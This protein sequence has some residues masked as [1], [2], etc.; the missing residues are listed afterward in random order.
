MGPSVFLYIC[1]Y[2]P[3]AWDTALA[4]YPI[5]TPWGELLKGMTI[6]SPIL[7]ERC[8]N[9]FSNCFEEWE[10][11]PQVHIIVSEMQCSERQGGCMGDS[12]QPQSHDSYYLRCITTAY[13]LY[14]SHITQ[15][16][17]MHRGG[18]KIG[19]SER[20]KR[21]EEKRRR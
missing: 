7:A 11:Q 17:S 3:V 6:L 21:E 2:S 18:W 19:R 8:D 1:I 10:V 5:N 20:R 4:H 15:R 12:S 16:Y 9:P 13:H 14:Q